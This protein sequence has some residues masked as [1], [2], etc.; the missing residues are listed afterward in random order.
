MP[1]YLPPVAASP[2]GGSTPED[3]VWT[4]ATEVGRST[5]TGDNLTLTM[6]VG[7]Q[8]GDLIV[9]SAATRNASLSSVPSVSTGAAWSTVYYGDTGSDE[10][11]GAWAKIANGT[12]D[13]TVT[14][15]CNS[16]MSA[17]V[18]FVLRRDDGQPFTEFDSVG[19]VD[20]GDASTPALAGAL[21]GDI[22]VGIWNGCY[23]GAVAQSDIGLTVNGNRFNK[24]PFAQYDLHPWASIEWQPVLLDQDWPAIPHANNDV[25]YLSNGALV[26]R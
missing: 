25:G 18:L 14:L 12:E 22:W 5:D 11:A 10:R 16:L 19:G 21:A 20:R 6:P 9:V 7:V 4:E 13:E 17:G 2:S 23:D 1:L 24:G 15:V 3:W 26:V 8:A